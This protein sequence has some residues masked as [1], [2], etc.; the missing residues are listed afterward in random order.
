MTTLSSTGATG[1]VRGRVVAFDEHRGLGVVASASGEQLPFHCT[2]IAD[3]SRRV[4]VGARVEFSVVPGL[5]GRR[6]ADGLR[7]S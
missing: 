2:A 5:L 7:V 4:P 6:E 3:G 1:L